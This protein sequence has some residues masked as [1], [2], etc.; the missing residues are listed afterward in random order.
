MVSPSRRTPA[1]ESSSRSNN[2]R[3][4]D[5]LADWYDGWVG[6]TGSEHHRKLALPA[7]LELLRPRAGER[8]LDVGAGQGVLAPAIVQ[9]GARYVG[10]EM[11]PR[12]LRHARR[13]RGRLGKFVR[14][15]ARCLW[16]C[17]SLGPGSFDGVVFLL[18]IQDMD[19]LTDVLRSAAWALRP[20]GRLV[21][22]MTHPCFRVPRQSGWG[23]DEDRRLVY[24]R[25]DSYLTSRSVPLTPQ[26]LKRRRQVV[27]SFHRPLQEYVNGLSCQ[28]LLVERI[29]ELATHSHNPDSAGR[30]K[31]H[32]LA[33]REIP[34]F[35]G[36]KAVKLAETEAGKEQ[37]NRR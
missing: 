23:W 32:R 13:H 30:A 4:W 16:Q 28:G 25:V 14:A 5:R 36:L 26:P 10:V 37:V 7:A 21:M 33:D 29:E 2:W 27:W 19:P 1:P 9:G 24:R 34:L 15:D 22:V 3:C 18:S 31:A 20:G 6:P 35:L 17:P 12:L 8:I 11:S